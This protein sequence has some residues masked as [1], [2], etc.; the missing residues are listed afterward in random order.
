M[1]KW[2]KTFKLEGIPDRQ[3]ISKTILK[4][5]NWE[6]YMVSRVM[7]PRSSFASLPSP[8]DLNLTCFFVRR[9]GTNLLFS[10]RGEFKWNPFVLSLPRPKHKLNV[11]KSRFKTSILRGEKKITIPRYVLRVCVCIFGSRQ[12]SRSRQVLQPSTLI[13]TRV[14]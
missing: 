10:L 13:P 14:L 9:G 12:F 6:L 4:K 11:M 2:K 1:R 3:E 7:Q 5:G 8:L